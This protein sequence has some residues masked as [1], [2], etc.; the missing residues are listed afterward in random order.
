MG[1]W[2]FLAVWLCLTGVATVARG[3]NLRHLSDG[4]RPKRRPLAW[5]ARPRSYA[6]LTVE[7]VKLGVTVEFLMWLAFLI[8][9]IAWGISIAL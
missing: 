3:Y 4:A 6:G 2:V 7:Q 8:V 5:V 9:G 1:Q